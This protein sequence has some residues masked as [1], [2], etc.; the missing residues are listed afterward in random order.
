MACQDDED[1]ENGTEIVIELFGERIDTTLPDSDV[2]T[3][4]ES[5][6]V[7]SLNK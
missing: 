2:S 4:G 7:S 3:D 1:V 5:S 6:F